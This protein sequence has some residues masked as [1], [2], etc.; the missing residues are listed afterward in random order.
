MDGPGQHVLVQALLIQHHIGLDVP[1]AGGA[2]GDAGGREDGVQAVK[3]PAF[4]AVVPQNAAVQLQHLAASRLLVQAVDVL[5]DHGLQLPL[6]FPLGQLPVGGVGLG[7]GGQ[8]LGPVKVVKFRLVA[9][10]EAVAEDGF[11]RVL[12]LLVI[13]AVHTAEIRDSGLRGH[14]GPAEKHHVVRF[15]HPLPQLFDPFRHP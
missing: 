15:R 3:G 6:L 5:G 10:I 9:D 12:E 2:P 11:R 13:Q 14:S 1:A 8:H 4:F 7:P